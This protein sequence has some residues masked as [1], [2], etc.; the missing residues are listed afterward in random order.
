MKKKNTPIKITITN[1]FADDC[2]TA[3]IYVGSQ[4]TPVNV[5]LDTGSSTSWQHCRCQLRALARIIH[6]PVA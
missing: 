5:F 6:E 4:K 2:F 1:I 3:P